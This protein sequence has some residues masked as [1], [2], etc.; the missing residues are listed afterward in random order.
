MTDPRGFL[1]VEAQKPVAR[2]VHQRIRDYKEVYHSLPAEA[3][4]AQASR[5]MDCGVP[6]CHTGCPLGN[7]IPDWND[8]P[9]TARDQQLSR[10]HR[11]D[12]PRALRGFV[13][14]RHQQSGRHDQEHR[15]RDRR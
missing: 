3:T 2:P 13:R 12:L 9:R 4:R 15:G 1:I 6:F 11:Q 5:C 7:Q 14:P 8:A 10:V